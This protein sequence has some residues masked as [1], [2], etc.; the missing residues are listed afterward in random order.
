MREGHPQD[1]RQ[2]AL[3]FAFSPLR[4]AVYPGLVPP[5]GPDSSGRAR[6]RG[7]AYVLRPI[8]TAT[9]FSYRSGKGRNNRD[10]HRIATSPKGTLP[11]YGGR[12]GE[13]VDQIRELGYD[14]LRRCNKIKVSMEEFFFI[15]PH[16]TCGVRSR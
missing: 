6:M 2:A 16:Q 4:F 10:R 8:G 13:Q 1:R 7:R 14:P 12:G 15:C 3:R 5:S 11:V 9:V